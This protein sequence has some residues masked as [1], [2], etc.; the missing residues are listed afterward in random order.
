GFPEHLPER[1]G[2]LAGLLLLQ[3]VAERGL[4]LAEQFRQIE[5]LTGL[6]H[7]YDRLDLPLKA[8]LDLTALEE[9]R[10]L[11]GLR[12]VGVERLDGVKWLYPEA[13]L[14]FRPS[15]TE[16]VLRLYA[17]ATSPELVQALLR[18]ARGV[19]GV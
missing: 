13:W 9:P 19:V 17:E 4:E 2:L 14:L 8:P 15:G 10:P 11:A 6:T 16:P 1:D 7:A 18:E 5:A 12:P 3:S